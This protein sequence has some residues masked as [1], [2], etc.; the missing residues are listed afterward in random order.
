[1]YSPSPNGGVSQ[2]PPHMRA[3]N[4]TAT[5][6]NAWPD[7]ADGLMKRP[8]TRFDRKFTS[9]AG[10]DLR[11]ELFAYDS[12]E[13]Y[14][15]VYGRS[16][17]STIF[18]AFR[19]G[20][21]E[22]TVTIAAAATTYMGVNSPSS[23][24]LRIV[25]VGRDM[26]VINTTVAT[27]VTTSTSYTVARVRP[28]YRDLIAFTATTSDY[29]RVEDD[30][31]TEPL[32]YWQY[33]PGTYTAGHINFQTLSN[34]WTISYGYWNDA[35]YTDNDGVGFKIAFRRV[36]LTGFTAATWTAAT[37]TLTKTGAFTSYTFR[38]GDMIY[39]SAGTGHTVGWYRIASRTSNDAVVLA[40]ATGLSGADNADTAANVTDATYSETNICRIGKQI[41]VML[42]FSGIT[43][44]SMHDIAY[45]FTK[46]MRNAGAEGASCAW[47]PQSAGGAFQITGPYVGNN[48]IVYAPTTATAGTLATNGDLTNGATD[49]FYNNTSYIQVYGGTGGAAADVSDT[50]TPES[51][52]TRVAAP[53]QS[54]ASLDTTKMPHK[55]TRTSANNLSLDVGAWKS[56]T[57]GTSTNNPAPKLITETA[58][59]S[60]MTLFQ[61]RLF[62]AG[63]PYLAGSEIGDID[64]FFIRDADQVVDSDRIDRTLS[65]DM[66]ANIDWMTPYRNVLTLFS[67]AGSQYEVSS[68]ADTL[69]STSI[70]I[71]PT[72]KYRA[73]AN[74]RPAVAGSEVFFT[75]SK[76][77]GNSVYSYAY[78][79]LRVTSVA[80][81]INVHCPTYVAGTMKKVV[82]DNNNLTLIVLTSTS[83]TLYIYRYYWDGQR[84]VHS[85]WAK[86]SFDS[87]YRIS[88]IVGVG[89]YC[90]MLTENTSTHTVT[91]G[92]P[93]LTIT[94]H[95]LVDG[96]AITL[97]ESTTTPSL[98]GTKYVDV[99]D[100]NTVDIY[101]DAILATPSTLTVG[102][103]VVAYS[104]AYIVEKLPLSKQVAENSY[105]YPI[106][107]DRQLTLTG[108]HAAGTTTWTLPSTPTVLSGSA[109]YSGYGSTINMIVLGP[110]HGSDAGTTVTPNGY[111]ST[112]VTASGNHA[113][114]SAVLGRYFDMT[115][116]LT[117]PFVRDG[118]MVDMHSPTQIETVSI[119]YAD[120]GDVEIKATQSL[121]SDRTREQDN[122][123]TPAT[124]VLHTVLSGDAASMTLTVQSLASPKPTTV[125]GVNYE[126]EYAPD[127]V[128]RK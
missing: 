40:S 15:L 73:N 6:V 22:A 99:I 65:S 71:T 83:A 114:G 58:K 32:G 76:T 10:A 23:E 45:E 96:N 77:N 14:I 87:T 43:V 50:S 122:G 33:T 118:Q 125:T 94:A 8:G 82:A 52:W 107:L 35:T 70:A 59:I 21:N 90:W 108:S 4:Q 91:T 124:G 120:T 106:H 81:Q 17:G 46:A 80:S 49:P 117:R 86:A 62:I 101:D 26:Y 95:G 47:V 25:P 109:Q 61:G 1:M 123:V 116:E 128:T 121:R 44:T 56:R 13:E 27:G 16:G 12:D 113:D 111:S 97:G 28:T 51:R 69:T 31:E 89:D 75:V 93:R 72:T 100:A 48:A 67:S 41:E 37:L 92:T 79:D 11:T 102:G 57:N 20:G 39:L 115:A 126:I 112:T 88:D 55:L 36:A 68:S 98:N 63:G 110:A 18:R 34:P 60:D 64:D 127:G 105:A 85:A 2:Q 3:P 19:V 103:T 29:L 38:N 84:K 74:V 5:C 24:D 53:L 42:N 30:D 104:G 9:T 119:G 66:Q 78:D 54:G 7:I